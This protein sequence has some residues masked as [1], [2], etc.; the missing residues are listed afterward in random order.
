MDIIYKLANS[1]QDFESA[2]KLFQEYARSLEVDLSFQD[3]EKELETIDKQ[4]NK[5]RGAL[6]LVY[7]DKI[8]IGCTGIREW[9]NDIAE[10]KRM[11]VKPDYR[12]QD[13]GRKLLEL[14][15][16]IAKELSYKKMRLDTLPNM[17]QALSIYRTFGFYEIS[18]YRFN[19]VVGTV[20]MEKL[21]E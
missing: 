7:C 2:K 11:Y 21:L 14:S 4:Y 5:P 6:L 9:D 12:G 1:N 13:I 15:F 8:A 10:L 17:K 20:Y 19:P 16:E 3:F 18:T